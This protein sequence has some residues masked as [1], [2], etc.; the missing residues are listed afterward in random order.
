VRAALFGGSAG[1][2]VTVLPGAVAP[3]GRPAEPRFC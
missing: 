2:K 3:T 1:D